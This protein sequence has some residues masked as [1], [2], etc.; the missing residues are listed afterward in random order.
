MK[1]KHEKVTEH[2]AKSGFIFQKKAWNNQVFF[3]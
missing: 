3:L 2:S 1:A